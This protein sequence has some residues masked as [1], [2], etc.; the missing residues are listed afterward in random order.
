MTFRGE[1]LP[2]PLVEAAR[3]GDKAAFTKLIAEYAFLVR[4][5]AKLYAYSGIESEDLIQEGMIGFIKAVDSYNPSFGA[6]FR[7]YASLCV[8]RSI[9]SAVNKVFA[10][11]SIPKSAVMPIDEADQSY[12][13]SVPSIENEVLF[14]INKDEL[15]KELSGILSPFEMKVFRLLLVE[16]SYKS[17]ARRLNCSEK[18]VDNAV[19]RIRRKMNAE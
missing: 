3:G 9:I 12:A 15:I 1:N 8:D 10:K 14:K 5:R 11:H 13:V 16:M 2:E 4:E 6:S 18:A 17:I 7:T 19:Q